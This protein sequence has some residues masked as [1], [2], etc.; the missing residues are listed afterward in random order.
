MCQRENNP[1]IEQ[2]SAE[3]NRSSM[4]HRTPTPGSFL[5]LAPKQILSMY[6][7]IDKSRHT[8]LRTIHKKLKLKIVRLTKARGS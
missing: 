3:F 8:K 7:S 2:T 4:Q 6:T 5:Q 1:T